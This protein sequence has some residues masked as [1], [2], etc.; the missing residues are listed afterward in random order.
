MA[1]DLVMP[2]GM[3]PDEDAISE[4]PE[5]EDSIATDGA[6]RGES[7]GIGMSSG[8]AHSTV[9]I[10]PLQTEEQN[11]SHPDS[12]PS[13]IHDSPPPSYSGS[14]CNS[15]RRSSYAERHATQGSG[16]ALREADIG[17]GVD[18]IRPVKKVDTA[19]S[20]R[21]SSEYVGS[22]R[23]EGERSAPSSPVKETHKRSVSEQRRAGETV[24]DDIVLPVLERV[25]VNFFCLGK[26]PA[27]VPV[28]PSGMIKT[29]EKS[30]PSVCC[31]EVS[32]SLKRQTLSSHT[33]SS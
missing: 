11:K 30:S 12:P 26:S 15:T 5:E 29:L 8:A 7:A 22:I 25:I 10:K 16:V 1:K 17:T 21:L 2:P 19:G 9:I 18:T 3:I 14:V 31:L 27:H 4:Y 13:H 32:A 6:T 24:V 28:R 20:L 33:T 23:R